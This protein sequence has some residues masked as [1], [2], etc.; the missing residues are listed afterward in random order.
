MELRT[1]NASANDCFT[2]RTWLRISLK[3]ETNGRATDATDSSFQWCAW[4]DASNGRR[5]VEKPA[6][7]PSNLLLRQSPNNWS[8]S[9]KVLGKWQS[10]EMWSHKVLSNTKTRG[11]MGESQPSAVII[12]DIPL[13]PIWK[14]V[15]NSPPFQRTC[16][17]CDQDAWSGQREYSPIDS[18]FWTAI[19]DWKKP[20]KWGAEEIERCRKPYWLVS[21]NLLWAF[22][23][24]T[25]IHLPLLILG[26]SFTGRKGSIQKWSGWPSL[27]LI[28]SEE[29][30]RSSSRGQVRFQPCWIPY[31][32][33]LRPWIFNEVRMIALS[34]HPS[35]GIPKIWSKRFRKDLQRQ[36]KHASGN[37]D[38]PLNRRNYLKRWNPSRI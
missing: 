23:K 36:L 16:R 31:L 19:T 2:N 14:R 30:S 15:C 38:D 37:I 27:L 3:T 5:K 4:S 11:I 34:L 25:S 6:Q 26:F 7:S 1:G 12:E 35:R 32:L 33:D 13:R 8:R 10:L 21:N 17:V 9:I 22:I 20:R 24:N 29:R 28:A 18:K